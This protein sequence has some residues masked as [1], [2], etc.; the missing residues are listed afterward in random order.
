M[1]IGQVLRRQLRE[2]D[3]VARYAGDE[4][5]I[6]LPMTDEEQAGYVIG[7][8]QTAIS[9]YTYTTA[10]GDRVSVTAS[11]GAATIPADGQSFEELMMQA[12][13]RMYRSK[14]D[15]RS[16]PRSDGSV[17]MIPRRNARAL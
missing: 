3:M 2:N 7:R 14:D 8:V 15:T 9:Q 10:E 1:N 5:V 13:K 11:I 17:I 6:L 12:D 4:F 16:R